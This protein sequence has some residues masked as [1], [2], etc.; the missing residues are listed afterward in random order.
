VGYGI[1][2]RLLFQLSHPDPSDA[3][4]QALL[5]SE[6]APSPYARARELTLIMACRSKSRA[7]AA[8]NQLLQEFDDELARRRRSDQLL[9]DYSDAFRDA[10]RVDIV[11]LD[12]SDIR[13]VFTF[14]ENVRQN[15]PY[16]T[17]VVLNAAMACFIGIKWFKVLPEV[18]QKGYVAFYRPRFTIQ[19]V[20]PMTKDG[21]G[22]VWTANVLSPYILIKR[23]RPS[24]QAAPFDSARILWMSSLEAMRDVCADDIMSDYQLTTGTGSYEMSK[25]QIS[26]LAPE[27]QHRENQLD[28]VKQPHAAVK[29][30]LV[31]PGITSSNIYAAVLGT[32]LMFGMDLAFYLARLAGSPYHIISAFNAALSATHIILTSLLNIKE[33]DQQ[34]QP[35]MFGARCDRLGRPFVGTDPVDEWEANRH[36]GG[37]IADQCERLYAAFEKK[38]ERGELKPTTLVNGN[39]NGSVGGKANGKTNGHANG[40][41]DASE[42]REVDTVLS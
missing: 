32:I 16:V 29:H 31:H 40:V 42:E 38:F 20:S 15:Y 39:S 22:A 23:L 34:D 36:L 37:Q 1:C 10:L 24:L 5:S 27:L 7:E 19:S 21:L 33:Q 14:C 18:L 11:L 6:D 13:S 25:Y 26:L 41:V 17:H 12:I 30:I 3:H 28:D 35:V 2:K 8:R 9:A 4:A